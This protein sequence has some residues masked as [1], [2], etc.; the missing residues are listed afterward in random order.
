MPSRKKS[1]PNPATKPVEERSSLSSSPALD[2]SDALQA[3]TSQPEKTRIDKA[4]SKGDSEAYMKSKP[5]SENQ[6]VGTSKV[7][8]PA[9]FLALQA[10]SH[11]SPILPRVGMAGRGI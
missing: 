11:G 5:S 10:L 2:G 4:N 6:T 8:S 7:G 1:K 3:E 9:Y